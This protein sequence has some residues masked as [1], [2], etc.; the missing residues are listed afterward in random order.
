MYGENPFSWGNAFPDP[1]IQ[2][3][4]EPKSK[5]A[6]EKLGMA[7]HKLEDEDLHLELPIIKKPAKPWLPAWANCI[8]KLLW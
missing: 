1:V 8:W 4:I 7:M 2:Q 6:Q 5:D 3:A